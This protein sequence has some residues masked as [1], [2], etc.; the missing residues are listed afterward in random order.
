LAL[1]QVK[2]IKISPVL[3]REGARFLQAMAKS[4]NTSFSVQEAARRYGRNPHVLQKLLAR[5][6]HSGWLM[7]INRARYLT[8]PMAQLSNPEYEEN[9]L[10]IAGAFARPG[11]L[12]YWTALSQHGLT[13]QLPKTVYVVT[14]KRGRV[15]K[16]KTSTYRFIHTVPSRL[17]GMVAIHLGSTPILFSDAEKTLLDCMDQP[18]YAGG[19]LEVM[20]AFWNARMRVDLDR[21]ISYVAKMSRSA[22]GRRLGFLMERFQVGS[23]EQ[24]RNLESYVRTGYARLDPTHLPKGKRI[25]RW[26]ILINMS[27]EDIEACREN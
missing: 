3:G 13:T 18:Q 26:G 12:G 11:Y 14:T 10:I 15:F 21:M 9:P 16:W 24:R 23:V 5:L 19:M 7:R 22:V 17:F 6:V 4:G 8:I 2:N 27:D 1:K 20:R 25:N